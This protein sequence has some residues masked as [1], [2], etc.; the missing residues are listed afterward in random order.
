MQKSKILITCAKGIPSY[1]KQELHALNFPLCSE[2]V[3]GVETEGVF[4]DTLLLNL[5]LRTGHRVLFPVMEFNANTADE[6]YQKLS[7]IAWEEYVSEDG[8]ALRA[9]ADRS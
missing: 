8:L 4:E 2:L 6:L 1:L 9:K 3:A 5:F 7:A